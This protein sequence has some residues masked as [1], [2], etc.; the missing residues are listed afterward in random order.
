MLQ[1]IKDTARRHRKGLTVAAVILS[2]GLI[3]FIIIQFTSFRIP[4]LFRKITGFACPG[5]G[6]TALIDKLAHFELKAAVSENY[7]V[8]L[9]VPIYLII[10]AVRIIFKPRCLQNNGKL[11]NAFVWLTLIL[12]ILFGIIR[13]IS[14]FEFLLPS[15][16]R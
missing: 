3:Y 2:I 9:L 8:S 15:Y 16:M 7:A 6:I 12:L 13:N 5:C 4:C 14:G 10:Y 1:K 11:F